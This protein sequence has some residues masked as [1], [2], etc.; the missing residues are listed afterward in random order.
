MDPIK[1]P[2]RASTQEHLD[3][4]DIRDDLIVLKDGS[5]VLVIATTA[6]NFGLLSEKEQDATIFAYAALINSLTFSG[7][8]SGKVPGG[9]LLSAPI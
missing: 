8:G 9:C 2:I 5:C 6:I 1:I 7:D 3:I 4:E